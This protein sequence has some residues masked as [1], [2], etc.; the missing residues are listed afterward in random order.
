M[1]TCY[2]NFI[3]LN[4]VAISIFMIFIYFKLILIRIYL[5]LQGN[6]IPGY[7]SSYTRA[8]SL[9]LLLINASTLMTNHEE[10]HIMDTYI[11]I[12]KFTI[13]KNAQ[14]SHSR[15]YTIHVHLI[16]SKKVWGWGIHFGLSLHKKEEKSQRWTIWLEFEPINPTLCHYIT[17]PTDV[18]S[19]SNYG[20]NQCKK[21]I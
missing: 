18:L 9:I 3:A 20:N 13:L 6:T 12:L 19:I 14:T 2:P 17:Q 16:S 15:N 7:Y 8:G 4:F 21:C 11:C 10:W 5:Y 1:I